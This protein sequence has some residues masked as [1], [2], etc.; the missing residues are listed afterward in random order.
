MPEADYVGLTRMGCNGCQGQRCVALTS[1]V[2]MV[3]GGIGPVCVIM[4]AGGSVVLCEQNGIYHCRQEE[5]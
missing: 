1:V 4:I 2:S 5:V 3:A